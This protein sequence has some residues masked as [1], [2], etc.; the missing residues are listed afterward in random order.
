MTARIREMV[1][2]DYA[3]L[4]TLWVSSEGVG[5]SDADSPAGF[6]RF[7]K[8]SPGLS[9][10]ALNC[11]RLVGGVLCGHD[12]RRGY[13]HHLAV[14]SSHRRRGVARALVARCLSSFRAEGIQKC[15][16][17]V[18]DENEEGKLFWE[19]SGWP[20]RVELVMYSSPTG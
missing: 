7:L 9:F 12:G 20:A 5:L 8:R 6:E 2:T 18:F 4:R 14:S 17:F 11:D 3:L 15:H 16:V 10:V 1:P 13:I 19:T